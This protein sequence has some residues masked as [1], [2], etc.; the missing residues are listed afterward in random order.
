MIFEPPG[1]AL[2]LH[3]FRLEFGDGQFNVLDLE[4]DM[5]QAGALFGDPLGHTGLGAVAFEQLDVALTD[6]QHGKAG[7][8]DLLLV[9]HFEPEGVAHQVE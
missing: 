5:E 6:R 4:A 3:V 2:Q 1:I 8:A 9:F 7:L